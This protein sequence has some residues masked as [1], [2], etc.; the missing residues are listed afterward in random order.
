MF[1]SDDWFRIF[2]GR[3]PANLALNAW[4]AGRDYAP[5]FLLFSFKYLRPLERIA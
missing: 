1:E 5:D 2:P 4:V 3:L